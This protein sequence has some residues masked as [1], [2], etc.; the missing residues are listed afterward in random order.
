MRVVVH[1]SPAGKP[2]GPDRPVKRS[3]TTKYV[4]RNHQYVHEC[5]LHKREKWRTKSFKKVCTQYIQVH[6]ILWPWSMYSVYTFFLEYV[7]ENIHFWSFCTWYIPVH[8]WWKKYVLSTHLMKNVCTEYILRE[9]SMYQV[10]TGLCRFIWVS[11]YSM[12]HTC[13]HRYVLGTYNWSRFQ[14]A[15]SR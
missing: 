8:T 9:K 2:A 5:T 6:T 10:Q 14:M 7:P 11:Y 1:E 15:P 12:V 3:G 13:T 4:L